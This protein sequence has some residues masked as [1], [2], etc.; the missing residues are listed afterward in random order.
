[1]QNRTSDILPVTLAILSLLAITSKAQTFISNTSV[2]VTPQGDL[3]SFWRIGNA[4]VREDFDATTG[5]VELQNASNLYLQ[6][7]VFYG[8]YLDANG[9]LC[10]SLVFSQ[11]DD[12]TVAPGQEITLYS[13]ASS[14]FAA[15]QP[16]ELRLFIL[17]QSIGKTVPPKKW[18]AL[19]RI[20][21]TIGI[22]SLGVDEGR[23]QLSP[24]SGD[25]ADLILAK[26]RVSET[27]QVTGVD[28]LNAANKPIQ[29][30]FERFVTD[31]GTFYPATNDGVPKADFAL[32]LVRAMNSE[33]A[34]RKGELNRASAPWVKSYIS[35]LGGSDIPPVT[36]F[37]F[38]RPSSEARRLD[39]GEPLPK[40][41]PLASSLQLW[42]VQ[43][44]WSVPS[45]RW[46]EDSTMP[47]NKRRE[48]AVAASE[49]ASK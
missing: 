18:H 16:K 20:P 43:T 28:I 17:Q 4:G 10:F 32:V 6:A 48:L 2:I 23:L 12:N 47:H 49:P 27:G 26:V 1:M 31:L 34:L 42:S 15:V 39:T 33:D 5:Y 41:S 22:R 35:G 25:V 19:V 46:V 29:Q 7:G 8:E 37:L 11:K 14:M 45:F 44:D 9:R 36:E 21:V 40:S 3:G 24:G 38:H 30:W 13:A